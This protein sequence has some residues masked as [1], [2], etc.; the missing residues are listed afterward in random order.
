LRR[1]RIQEYSQL[2]VGRYDGRHDG[3]DV[4]SYDYDVCC[5]AQRD[6]H[7]RHANGVT[8]GRSVCHDQ[9]IPCRRKS[10]LY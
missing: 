5:N 9:R 1:L 6:P 10:D 4:S 2:Y 8:G 7:D 3:S